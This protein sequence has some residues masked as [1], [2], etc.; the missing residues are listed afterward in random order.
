MTAIISASAERNERI[1][2]VRS[3][4]R[5]R[6]NTRRRKTRRRCHVAVSFVLEFANAV[7]RVNDKCM[8]YAS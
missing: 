2:R 7:V 8:F 3:L 6:I 1:T 5:E 4:A